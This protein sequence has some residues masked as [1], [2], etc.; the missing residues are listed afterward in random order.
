[1]GDRCYMRVTCRRQ[2]VPRFEPLGFVL[3]YEADANHPI[4]ELIDEEANYAHHGRLPAD[5]PFLAEHGPGGN[6]GNGLVACDGHRQA[7]IEAGHE[8]GFV[9]AWDVAEDAPVAGSLAAI[10]EYRAVW[11][12]VE[13]LFERL[14]APAPA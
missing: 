3:D 10:R 4:V 2:D 9:I 5:V 13:E 8:G 14:A 1:M 6:F 7:D 12:A 11:R